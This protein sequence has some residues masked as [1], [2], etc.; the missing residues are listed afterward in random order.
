M[1]VRHLLGRLDFLGVLYLYVVLVQVLLDELDPADETLVPCE[2]V[3]LEIEEVE[4]VYV[5]VLAGDGQEVE[6]TVVGYFVDGAVEA[7][8]AEERDH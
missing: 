4:D 8:K 1:G 3:L 7:L 2:L 6:L 5:V